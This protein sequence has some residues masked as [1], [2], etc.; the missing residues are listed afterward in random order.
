MINLTKIASEKILEMSEEEGIDPIIRVKVIGGGC[1]GFSFDFFFEETGAKELDEIE[2]FGN[3]KV[4]IDQM[5]HQYT[6]GVTI[7][8]VSSLMWSG[9]KF[10]HNRDT[11]CG[12]GS[13]TG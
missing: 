9:F 12:C 8:Y 7:D 1:N 3:I 10:I 13:F 4:I 2:E 6:D 11:S 5:S